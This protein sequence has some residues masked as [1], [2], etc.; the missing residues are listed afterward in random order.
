M[1]D[2]RTGSPRFLNPRDHI[3]FRRYDGT[4]GIWEVRA[5]LLG[6]LGQESVYGLRVIDAG[7]AYDEWGIRMTDLHVPCQLLEAFVERPDVFV[8]EAVPT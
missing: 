7:H 1:S 4:T 5:V 2:D 8:D 3:R 6:G